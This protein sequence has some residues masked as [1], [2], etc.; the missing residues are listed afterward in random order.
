M[1]STNII[2]ITATQLTQIHTH[3]GIR[4]NATIMIPI[5]SRNPIN[6]R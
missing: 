3:S 2:G 5:K 4:Q 6:G 1:F